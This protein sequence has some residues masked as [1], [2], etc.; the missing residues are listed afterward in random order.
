VILPIIVLLLKT[1]HYHPTEKETNELFTLSFSMISSDSVDVR[2]AAISAV[3]VITTHASSLARRTIFDNIISDLKS[4]KP[5]PVHTRLAA[6]EILHKLSD[7]LTP[8]LKEKETPLSSAITCEGC[9]RKCIQ[10]AP[11]L[12]SECVGVTEGLKVFFESDPAVEEVK[13]RALEV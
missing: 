6:L 4:K 2:Q 11:L 1:T 3:I 10:L 9:C 13:M 12:P 8:T 5:L 7:F